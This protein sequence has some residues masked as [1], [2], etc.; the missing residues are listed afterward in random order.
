[1]N[2][3]SYHGDECTVGRPKGPGC[4][5]E[6]LLM[7]SLTVDTDL[8]AISQSNMGSWCTLSN[9]L[10]QVSISFQCIPS[11]LILSFCPQHEF[12]EKIQCLNPFLN[13]VSLGNI[14]GNN[15]ACGYACIY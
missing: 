4:H 2:G 12:D 11:R 8:M 5:G 7:W 9:A 14:V 10:L 15:P 1:M 6:N 3:F 13:I